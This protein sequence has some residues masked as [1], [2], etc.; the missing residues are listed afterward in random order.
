MSASRQNMNLPAPVP[1]HE[2]A[3]TGS[4][5]GVRGELEHQADSG[6]ALF[7]RISANLRVDAPELLSHTL[8]GTLEAEQAAQRAAV[9]GKVHELIAAY[10]EILDHS[11]GATHPA[12]GE[13]QATLPETAQHKST[14]TAAEVD[15]NSP[16]TYTQGTDTAREV[17]I[18]AGQSDS[19][20]INVRASHS[21][22]GKTISLLNSPNVRRHGAHAASSRGRH[23]A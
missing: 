21:H 2:L 9:A 1:P 10:P 11:D 12:D 17:P 15:H 14:I 16:D 6:D 8:R 7:S 19:T 3:V 18:L 20:Q 22:R 5:E 23:A 4:L 13:I